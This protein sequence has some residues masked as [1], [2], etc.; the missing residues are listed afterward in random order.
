MSKRCL[1]AGKAEKDMTGCVFSTSCGSGT[2]SSTTC[3]FDLQG[4]LPPLVHID[5]QGSGYGGFFSESALA[6]SNHEITIENVDMRDN[7]AEVAY[8]EWTHVSTKRLSEMTG[9]GALYNA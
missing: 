3:V 8:D 9:V 6:H 4:G 5:V 1:I 2:S 7:I